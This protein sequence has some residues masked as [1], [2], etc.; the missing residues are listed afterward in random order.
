MVIFAKYP[1]S[2]EALA[3]EGVY[4]TLNNLKL[5]KDG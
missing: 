5:I 1:R 3:F 4:V 2:T